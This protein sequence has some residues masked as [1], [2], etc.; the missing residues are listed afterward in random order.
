MPAEARDP[1]GGDM[2]GQDSGSSPDSQRRRA[3]RGRRERGKPQQRTRGEHAAGRAGNSGGGGGATAALA[4]S[5]FR[6][7]GKRHAKK[8]AENKF[9]AAAK[10]AKAAKGDT[11]GKSSPTSSGGA[12]ASH[13]LK[14]VQSMALHLP[15]T[16]TK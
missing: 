6:D 8:R 13:A 16:P 5:A 10:R 3:A 7:A 12:N 9:L 4:V 1:G 15:G 11:K 14:K 2:H